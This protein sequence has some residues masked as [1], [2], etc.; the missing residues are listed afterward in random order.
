MEY[1]QGTPQQTTNFI[2]CC[3]CGTQIEPNPSNM[4]VACLRTQVDITEGIPKQGVIYFC[5][6]CERYLQPPNTWVA[7]QLESRELLSICLKKLKGLNK[8]RLIDAGFIWTEPHSM[9]IKLKVTI[10]KE[11]LNGAVLEQVFVVEFIVNNQM[12]DDCHRVEAK[13]FWRAVVQ[14]RQKTDHKKTF[15]FLEQLILKHKAHANTVNIKM[16]H[17]KFY[18]RSLFFDR[19]QTAQELVTHDPRNNTY[20]YKHTFSVEI[21]PIC[22]D[23]VICLPNKLAQALGS[24]NPICI[25]HKVTQTVHI[26][27][28]TT[29]QVAEISGPQYW[30]TPFVNLCSPKQLIE[31]MVMQVDIIPEKDK[32]HRTPVSNKHVLADFFDFTNANLNNWDV[33]KVKAEKLPD[34]VVVKKLFGDKTAR[35]RKRRWKLR[36]LNEDLHPDTASNER[37]Y[38]DFLEDLEEDPSYRQNINIYKD[39]SKITVENVE[40]DDEGLPQI[41]LQEMLDD[42]NIEDATGEEGG[43]MLE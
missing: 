34:V 7:A 24:I 2:L 13:D 17:V 29:L 43:P 30:R 41:S 39:S 26:I 38:T 20:V 4:C 14:L 10:Q 23:N 1:F 12:C 5:K 32:P 15:F 36:H 40:S 8:V 6:K 42:L 9:R 31:Y 27:D 16:A 37:D 35:N 33:D 22:K 25:C 11:V 3:Q 19:T 21:V 18:D 28:P